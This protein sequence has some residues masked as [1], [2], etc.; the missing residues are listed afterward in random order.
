LKEDVQQIQL[1]DDSASPDRPPELG[2]LVVEYLEQLGVKFV[3]GVP[4]GAIEPLYDA[5]ARSSRRGGLRPILARHE[6]GAAFMADGYARE[7][8]KLGV[9]CSTTGPGA[10]NLITGVASAFAENTPLLVI[11]A[12][13][14]L[15]KFGKRALQ[16]SSCTAVNTVAMFQSCCRFSSLVSHRGQLESKLLSAIMATQG[17]PPGPAHLSIPMDILCAPRRMR[18]GELSPRLNS[19]L[20]NRILADLQALDQLCVELDK[21]QRIALIIGDGCGE[22]IAQLLEFAELT[23]APII[24]GPSGKR[25]IDPHHPNYVGVLGFA[26]HASA[27]AIL[28]DEGIDLI[29]AV[30][31]RLGELV[32]SGWEEDAAL[33]EKLVHIDVSTA[34]FH[35]SPM[36]RL[37]VCGTLSGIFRSLAERVREACTRGGSWPEPDPSESAAAPRAVASNAPP[38][39]TLKHPGSFVSD[40]VPIKPPR[41]MNELARRFPENTRFI[42]DAGNSWA[43]ATHYLFPRSS[44][45][46]R[47]GMGFGSMAWGIGA[48]VGT[49]IG[50]PGSPVVC[51]TGDGSFMMSSMELSVAVAE[52]LPVIFVVLNDQALGM[53]KH[54][55]R[56]G[57]GEPIAFELPP[58]DFAL[59]ARSLGARGISVRTLEDLENLDI[60]KICTTPG[61]TLLDVYIDPEEVPPMGSRM[62]TLGR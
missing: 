18:D 58:V 41:L 54:G 28:R 19:L 12:Q 26:G 48:A 35:R 50:C 49:A 25:W 32:F 22:G 8:G 45:L 30:G 29:L 21:A 27:T 16:E 62:K 11:T 59:L 24:S 39:I 61:P 38:Q 31:T 14:A 13:T 5:M 9:C 37:H 47:V 1:S 60:E 57:G 56:M 10:T 53:V 15:P 6:A 42:I 40:A 43:W 55:Q 2:D 20:K 17:P 33:Q 23:N 46:Y 44:G 4:G 52:Q 34:H 3:F 51:L 36:A 7:T